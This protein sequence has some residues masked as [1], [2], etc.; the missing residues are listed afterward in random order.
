MTANFVGVAVIGRN[1]GDRLVRCLSSVDAPTIVYVDS[2][3]TDGSV[4]AAENLGAFVVRLDPKLPFTA[5]RARNAGCEALRRRYA[6]LKYVQF[7][8]GD[9]EVVDGWIDAAL[10]FID[11]R[12]DVAVVCGRRR[13]RYPDLSIYN[14]LCDI[15]WDTPVGEALSCGG[16]SLMRIDAF[17]A[18]GGFQPQIIAGEEPEFC[19]R[20]R[21]SGWKI[22]RLDREMTCH[23]AAM[24]RFS[25][26]WRRA[27]R[28]GYGYADVSSLHRKSAALQSNIY[29]KETLSAVFWGGI[30]PW[31]I[32]LGGM[33]H[34][35][36]LGLAILYPLQISRIAA[37]RGP[38]TA[39]SWTYALFM[40]LAKFA[41]V[42][43]ILKFWR[44]RWTHAAVKPIE[45]K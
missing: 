36:L 16:D 8:D 14:R 5:G 20:L 7:V 45:Y 29:R 41:A 12:N 10:A 38:M 2:G 3:S 42:Y 25:Q 24:T 44:A 17:I 35:I 34:P 9:C 43:G 37:K 32:V 30:L 18:V 39:E 13:E 21:N 26:W 1:E 40:M 6:Q 27:I 23:D 28:S 33:I 31:I 19:L 4:A 22:W 15:E 11:Q